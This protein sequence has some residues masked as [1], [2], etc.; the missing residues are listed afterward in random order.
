MRKYL[1]TLQN[2]RCIM[3]IDITKDSVSKNIKITQTGK[4]NIYLMGYFHGVM[5]NNDA[6]T[7]INVRD[8]DYNITFAVADIGTI[9][10][11]AGPWTLA[12][13]LHELEQHIFKL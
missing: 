1:L 4:P 12:D 5:T 13:A 9:H 3:A 10:T 8:G 11:T 6:G 2:N 7:H